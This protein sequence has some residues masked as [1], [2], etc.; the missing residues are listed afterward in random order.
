MALSILV[1]L[2][3]LSKFGKIRL[4]EEQNKIRTVQESLRLI[5]IVSIKNLVDF[6]VNRYVTSDLKTLKSGVFNTVVLNSIRS[7]LKL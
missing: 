2:K 7:F 6:V 1:F 5:K 3:K 4:D